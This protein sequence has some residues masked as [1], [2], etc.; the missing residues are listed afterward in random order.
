MFLL[1]AQSDNLLTIKHPART[2][3]PL[4]AGPCPRVSRTN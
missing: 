1:V 4:S 2:S 3:D